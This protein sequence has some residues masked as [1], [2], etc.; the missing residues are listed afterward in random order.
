MAAGLLSH[1]LPTD[2]KLRVKVASAGTHA[3]HGHP[4]HDYA[5]AAMSR[6]GIDIGTHRARQITRE[7]A[8]GADLILVME[9]A[10]V[11]TVKKL[12]GWSRSKPRMIGDF[13][14]QGPLEDIAD[15]YGAPLE[16]YLDCI[17]TL[18]PCIEGV[19]LWLDRNRV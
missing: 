10:H 14:P 19:L 5:V 3:L 18:R 17:R 16:A 13:H 11:S 8:R 7:M 6:T 1:S 15:P 12:L 9:A 2:L 4:A